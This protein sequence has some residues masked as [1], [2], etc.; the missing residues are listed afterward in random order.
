[1][2]DGTIL[3]AVD[4]GSNSFRLE[5]GRVDQGQ[6]ER[7]DYIKEAVRLGSGLDADRQLSA[8]AMQRGWDC[9]NRFAERL[10]NF[11]TRQVRAVATQTLRE[12]KNRD[13]FM[14]KGAALLGYPINVISGKEEG[15]LIYQGV[16]HLLPQSTESRL[17]IDIGGRST[18]MIVGKGF[19]AQAVESYRV[20]S[21]AWSDRYFEGG[22]VSASAFKTA[23][24]AAKAFFENGAKTFGAGA[25]QSAYGSSGT[26]NAIADALTANGRAPNGLTLADLLWFKEKLVKAENVG[27]LRMEGLKED[28]YPVLAGG[29]AVLIGVFEALEVKT[30]Y[31]AEGALRQGVLFDILDR[32]FSQTD[33]RSATVTRLA[34]RF[35]V[36]TA[37]AERV[38]TLSKSI[39]KDLKSPS[40]SGSDSQDLL[41]LGWSAQL[42]EIGMAIAHADYHKHGAYILENADAMGFSVPELQKLGL[43]VLGHRGKLKK[44]GKVLDDPR[45]ARQLMA[46]RLAVILCHARADCEPDVIKISE[47]G[48]S[49]PRIEMS[50]S[51]QWLQN[52]PQSA[53]LLEQEAQ[54]W[55]TTNP[56]LVASWKG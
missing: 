40:Y 26:I 51:R 39:Y 42:H 36:D 34:K 25:W 16:S 47:K 53:Y 3:A 31:A 48:S 2:I 15:R 52:F 24:V 49:S 50:V 33:M 41:E 43:L 13:A 37:Q 35:L 32:D 18:E 8:A 54:A 29:L 4:M 56:L 7:I 9:L 23:I 11:P 14:Q 5:L 46:L 21:A 30:M 1:M 10:K 27:K 17:V 6:I 22:N 45:F 19:A 20:G 55:S 44:L 12:A 38:A 28:R